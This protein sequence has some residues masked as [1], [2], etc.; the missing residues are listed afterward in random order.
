MEA[1]IKDETNAMKNMEEFFKTHDA[2]Y[3]AENAVFNNMN[4]G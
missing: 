3:V 4:T 2:I 1:G